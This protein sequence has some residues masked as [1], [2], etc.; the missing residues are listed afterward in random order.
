MDHVDGRRRRRSAGSD[1]LG[2]ARSVV[3][4]IYERLADEILDGALYPGQ[5]LRVSSISERM[6]VSAVPVREALRRLEGERLVAFENNRG[7]RVTE[8]SLEDLRDIYNTRRVT[9]PFAVAAGVSSQAIDVDRLTK[10]FDRMA[11]AYYGGRRKDAYRWHGEFHEAL[12]VTG[13]SPR[14]EQ[15]VMTLLDASRR[16]LRLAPGLPTE[17]ETLV[18]LHRAILD[19]VVAGDPAGATKAMEQHTDY[20]LDHLEYRRITPPKAPTVEAARD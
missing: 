5:P 8:I 1:E 10:V 19:A 18:N 15:I 20:S 9:E 6:D 2:G 12:V 14:L 7:A 11:D 13:T 4:D 3:D 16:Y 17:A